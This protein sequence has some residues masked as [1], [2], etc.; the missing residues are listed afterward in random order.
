[1]KSALVIKIGEIPEHGL[2]LEVDQKEAGFTRALNELGEGE[3]GS[4]S[5]TASFSLS[6]WPDRVDV[7][8]SLAANLAVSC[9]RCANVYV[10]KVERDFLRVFLRAE[11]EDSEELELSSEDLDR[12]LLPAVELDLSDL[13]HEELVLSL[14]NKPLCMADCKGICSGCGAELNEQECSCEPEIDHRWASLKALKL[15]S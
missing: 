9:S 7:E 5:G 10:Q 13:L 15:D 14:P 6:P 3:Q 4:S 8:G 2:Q 1:M 12:D 11:P